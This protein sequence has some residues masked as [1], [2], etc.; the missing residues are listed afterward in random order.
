VDERLLGREV[1]LAAV[2]AFLDQAGSGF[3]ALML[4]GEPGI[5]KTTVWREGVRR[6]EERGLSV[7][8]CRPAEAESKLSFCALTD[9]LEPVAAEAFEQLPD[10]QRQALEVVLLRAEAGDGAVEPRAVAAGVRATLVDLSALAPVLVAI[11]DTQWLDSASVRALQFALRRVGDARLGVLAARRSEAPRARER[12]ELAEADRL[13]LGPLSLAAVHELLKARLGRSLPRPLLL[14]VYETCGGNPFFALEIAREVVDSGTLPG[15][16]LPVPKDLRRL[17]QRRLRR[18]SAD[19]REVLLAAAASSEPTLHLLRAAVGRNPAVALEEAEH[20]EVVEVVGGGVAFSHPLY[21][22]AIY[23][24]A[25]TEQRRRLHRRLSMVV[26]DLEERARH[27]GS[28]A[29]GPSE[30][31]A[32]ALE[33]AGVIARMRGATGVAGAL[34]SDAV[35]TTPAAE[36]A[37]AGKRALLAAEVL[38]EAADTAASRAMLERAI[39]DLPTGSLRARAILELG[40]I[41]FYEDGPRQ[42][43]ETCGRALAEAADDP[44][45]GAEIQLHLSFVSGHDLVSAREHARQARGLVAENPAMPDDLV[46]ASLLEDA[47]VGLLTGEPMASEQVE[48]AREVMPPDG[49]SWPAR[50][51]HANLQ[52]WSKYTDDLLCARLLLEQAVA[53]RHEHGDEFAAAL[54][55]ASLAEVELWLGHWHLARDL[56][57][58]SARTIEQAGNPLWRAATLYQQALVSTHLGLEAEARSRAR[59]GLRLAERAGDPW[60]QTLHLS[61]LGLLD[62]SLGDLVAADRWLTSAANVVDAMGL[63][64][65]ARFRFQGD[66]LEA[67]LGLGQVERGQELLVQ[68]RRRA[69]IAPRPWIRAV[70]LRCGGLL[71]AARGE[72]DRA[73]ESADAALREFDRLPMPFELGRTLLVK[74]EIERRLKQKRAAKRSIEQAL[75]IFDEHGARLWSERAREELERTGL[76]RASAD[77]LTE[78][79]QRVAELAASGLTNREVAARL[80]M[81]PKTVEANLARAYRKLGIR[82]RAQ[83]GARL[84]AAPPLSRHT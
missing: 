41:H 44:R 63:V 39:A 62:L 79:E 56:A 76:R 64:E 12:L 25:S 78:T 10:P 9:L 29:T 35:R 82:S 30:E 4:E 57:E 40:L 8:C 58:A 20:A 73:L 17:V 72:L 67:V 75:T 74:G 55:K 54:A 23:A 3:A 81:S 34:F 38:F 21:A 66:Q 46:A 5:G 65:P 27:L 50:R 51:A 2:D 52:S 71:H 59:E 49:M 37:H 84:G 43:A 22:A 31:V 83:L 61:V 42:A 53:D 48:R 1:E 26:T 32:S 14:R 13:A 16:A 18:L 47:W 11:D 69:E 70:S 77:G 60:I 19:T 7:L 33:E 6:A 68:L 28:A 80:F 36:P 45:L 24:S 15:E